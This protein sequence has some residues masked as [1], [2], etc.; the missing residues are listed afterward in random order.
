MFKMSDATDFV[1]QERDPHEYLDL[2]DLDVSSIDCRKRLQPAE[3]DY[4]WWFP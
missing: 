3:R 2:V 1:G 4:M